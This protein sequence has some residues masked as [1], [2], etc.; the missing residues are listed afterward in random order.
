[1]EKNIFL[2]G[3]ALL[4]L[5]AMSS[6]TL[7]SESITEK[8]SE[9]FPQNKTDVEEALAGVYQNLN[10]AMAED[11]NDVAM[12]FYFISTVAGDNCLGGGGSND[13]R[14][15]AEDLLMNN[16]KNMTELFWKYRYQGINRANAFI[17]SLQNVNLDETTKAQA[18]G[19]AKFLRGFYYY[20]LASQY[21]SVPLLLTSAAPDSIAQPSAAKEWGQICQDL[22][23]AA[24][25]MPATPKTDGHVDKYAAEGMLARAYLFYTGMYCNG[26]ELS[27]LVS[28]N[29]KRLTSMKLADGKELDDAEVISLLKD[30]IDH[31]GRSLVPDFRE[32]WAYT[33]K[34]TAKDYAPDKG[35]TWAEDDGKANSEVLFSIKFNKLVS[36]DS[37]SSTGYANNICLYFGV[38]G[39]QPLVNTFPYGQGWGAGTVAPN[40]VTDWENAEPND[41]RRDASIENFNTDKWKDKYAYG[42]W[43]YVQ[44]TG[45]YDKKL[46]PISCKTTRTSE[47]YTPCFEYEMYGQDVWVNGPDV[48]AKGNIHDLVLLRLADVYLMY[49]EL[50][51]DATYMNKVRERT[52]LP[53]KPYTLQD[54]QN[55]RRWEL[56]FEG[57]RWNDIRRWHIAAACLAKQEGQPIYVSAK[58]GT[59][60]AHGG[61]YAARYNATAGFFK[62]PENQMSLLSKYLKQNPGWDDASANYGGWGENK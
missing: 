50:T 26:E 61:G 17:E 16:Q 30:C 34:Y 46:S 11:Q 55:E 25:T 49:S 39:N 3:A 51:G 35:L 5:G 37:K 48:M 29:Y 53:D 15:Q 10:A 7:D 45:Y 59:N 19:E 23:D 2:T 9:N 58:K 18:L 41:P 8:N 27:D 22:Y 40:F 60:Y 32:L 13:T 36:N 31:S 62:I 6:C 12:N 47:G 52:S 33:N 42:Q 21:G 28:T 43:D 20:E 38:R 4:L 44:E 54:L 1:M 56:C 14:F 24:I 57:T